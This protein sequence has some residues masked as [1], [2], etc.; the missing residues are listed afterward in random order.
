MIDT[1]R[2]KVHTRILIGVA[3]LV[4]SVSMLV[5]CIQ[6]SSL[7]T[8]TATAAYEEADT[9]ETELQVEYPLDLNTA[10]VEELMTIDGLGYKRASL[11]VEYRKEIGRYSSLEQLKNI[12]GFS[13]TTVEM[14]APYLTV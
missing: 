7:Y 14:I 9:D 1:K 5:I 13:N 3:L 8:D 12:S 2:A 11:I 6:R 4:L 10:T